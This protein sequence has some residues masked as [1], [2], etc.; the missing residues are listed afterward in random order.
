MS[1]W[2]TLEGRPV[3]GKLAGQDLELEFR[4]VV[5]TTWKEWRTLHPDTVG[6]CCMNIGKS[7]IL[8]T[9]R[10]WPQKRNL[11]IPLGLSGVMQQRHSEPAHNSLDL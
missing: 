8:L 9:L 3:I 11:L 1:L 10:F 7:L 6:R 5:T 2:S 4:P